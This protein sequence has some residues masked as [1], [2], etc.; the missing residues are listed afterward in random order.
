LG[1]L[2]TLAGDTI[3]YGLSTII[4]RLLNWLLMPFFIRT[5]DAEQFGGV[6]NIYSYIAVVLVLLTFG[7]ETGYFR[8]VKKDNRDKL[9]KTLGLTLTLGSVLFALL[10]YIFQGPITNALGN[11]Y[12]IA[13]FFVLGALIVS[14][15]AITSIPFADL[16]FR[17]QTLRYATLKFVSIILNIL[18]IILFL[19]VCPYLLKKGYTFINYFYDENNRLIYVFLSNLLSS[20]I[21]ACFLIPSIFKNVA[22]FDWSLLKIIGKYS[23]PIMLVGLFGMV[24]QNIDKI[25]MPHLISD[26]AMAAL[27]VYGANYKIGILMALFIQSYRLAFEPFFFK[28]G[29]NKA[30]KELYARILKFFVLFGLIIYV[31]V[32]LF[33]DVINTL[34]TED[35][36]E[37]NVIIPFIL[38]GQLFFGIYYSLSLWYKL[39]DKTNYGAIISCIGA[40]TVVVGNVLLVPKIGYIGA[41]IS[42]CICFFLMTVISYFLGQKYYPIKYPVIR[43][44]MHIGIALVLVHLSGL[45]AISNEIVNFAIKAIIFVSYI[46]FLY[47][48]ERKDLIKSLS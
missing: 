13:D 20:G 19:V 24:I 33:I 40:I 36:Y 27:A 30:S 9:L 26:N 41:A 7:F 17:N 28:E 1:K 11:E 48:V 8:F 4:G 47:I 46:T 39:T 5:L 45:I 25:M 6:V 12:L 38:L 31:G 23:Y 18:F 29:K 10:V 35:Y 42:S 14:L 43:I 3:I 32:L 21:I 16:R 2:K 15:D 34:L 44:V 22:A 37:G